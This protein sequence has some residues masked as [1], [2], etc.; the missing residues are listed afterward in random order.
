MEKTSASGNSANRS[1]ASGSGGARSQVSTENTS[2]SGKS[3]KIFW[4]GTRS[5]VSTEN[6]SYSGKSANSFCGGT[7]SSV[8]TEKMSYSGKSANSSMSIRLIF[9]LR[10]VDSAAGEVL[11]GLEQKRP[12]AN[13]SV[14][15]KSTKG[16]FTANA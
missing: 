14:S 13:T 6:M 12:M 9:F 3:A 4:D 7:R 1:P 15:G 5:S 11:F 8:S 10:L 16:E 2:Y